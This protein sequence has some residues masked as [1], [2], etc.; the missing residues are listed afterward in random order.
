MCGIVGFYDQKVS[1]D[2]GEKILEKMLACQSHRGPDYTGIWSAAPIYLGHNR[3]SILDLSHA[4]DQPMHYRNLTMIFNGEVYNFIELR[5][6]LRA[7][8]YEFHTSGDSEV[9][10]AAYHKWGSACVQRFIGMWAL[11]IWDT[12]AKTL[13]CSRDRFGIK[14]FHYIEDSGRLY[15]ASEIKALKQSPLFK[16]DINMTQVARGLHLGWMQYRDESYFKN[17]A[18]LPAAHNLTI[19]Q[20]S[21]IIEKYWDVDFNEQFKG[22]FEEK[23]EAFKNLFFDSIKLTERRD[24]TLGVCLSGGLDSSAIASALSI[25]SHGAE[26]KTFSAYYTGKDSVDER[27]FISEVLKKYPNIV[28]HY[29]SPTEEEIAAQ[30]E[31]IQHHM[32]VPMPSSSYI[33]QYFVMQ[34]AAKNGI[35]VVLDGQGSD[36][37]MG[38]YMHSFYRL[39]A[40]NMRGG[41]FLKIASTLKHHKER[42]DFS[43][44]KVADILAKSGLTALKNEESLYEFEFKNYFPGI[45]KG[46]FK[47]PF[48]L[49]AQKTTRLN[50]FLYNLIYV[51][52]LPT[53]LHTEDINAMAFSIE[54]RVPFLDHRLVQFCFSLDNEDK[55]HNAETKY[56][57]RKSLKGVLPDAIADRRDKKGFVTPGEVKWLRGKLSYLVDG[58]FKEMSEMI[59]VDKIGHLIKAFK[60]GENKNALFLWRLAMLRS[61]MRTV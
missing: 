21:I 34:L 36:E 7:F 1:P 42:Q 14:P 55:I 32:D 58:D 16:N 35:K 13:F 50:E 28:P 10:M 22:S 44:K 27:P 8:G 12:T 33:S 57:L 15:F 54:S 5:E 49:P 56:I 9:I 3:L 31:K 52:L 25:Y 45:L 23:K 48:T 46:N 18:I 51:T 6:E 59:E 4:A 30:F 39:L 24:V 26:L 53:L 11:A 41:E 38:G 17:V 29:I 2:S 60:A 37:I 40:D 43:F 47:D 19:S 20:G 61:W